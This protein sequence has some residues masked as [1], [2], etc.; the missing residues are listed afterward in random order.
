M[1]FDKFYD[2]RNLKKCI[3]IWART[4]HQK[5]S[6]LQLPQTYQNEGTFLIYLIQQSTVRVCIC[7]LIAL[8]LQGRMSRNFEG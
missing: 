8:K 4:K 1:I 6:N 7:S 5:M 2:F 3:D